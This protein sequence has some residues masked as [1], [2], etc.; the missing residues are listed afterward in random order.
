MILKTDGIK[1]DILEDQVQFF[2]QHGLENPERLIKESEV[3][4]TGHRRAVYRHGDG[5]FY[6]K[7]M[8]PRK[9]SKEWRNW[10]GLY[11]KGVRTAVP[12]AMGISPDHGY[13]ISLAHH[14]WSGLYE[15]FDAGGYRQ[16]LGVLQAL[17]RCIRTMHR[18]GFYHGDLH[19]GNFLARW[20][21]GK[22]DIVMVDF[23]RGRFCSLSR[24]QRLANLAGLAVS[25]YFFLTVRER[26]AFLTG[27]LGGSRAACN[28]L[29]REGKQLEALIL[30]RASRVADRKV[31][32]FR[33]VN[34]Y[35][36]RLTVGAPGYKGVCFRQNQDAV[37]G[38][39]LSSPLEFLYGNDLHVLKDSRSVRVVRC[40]DICIKY[41]KRRGPKDV[42]KGRL[43]LS[44]GKKSFRWALAL[45]YRSI[46]TPD[47]L[48]YVDGQRGD[49]F[50]VSR[51]LESGQKL[52]VHLH[53]ASPQQREAC[54]KALGP[55]LKT[56]FYRGIYHLDLKSSNILVTTPGR[57]PGFYLIDTDGVAIFWKGSRTLLRKSLLRIT[58]ALSQYFDGEALI[59]FVL[60]CLS[61]LPDRL[62]LTSSPEEL[63]TRAFEIEA[64]RQRKSAQVND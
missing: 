24:R 62:T 15:I 17:G 22:P 64:G 9:A 41:Y 1:W 7:R 47:P 31:R 58:R 51:F 44:K 23:Q 55:F 28:F 46:P 13:L 36:D 59:D 14:G 43:G 56:L 4:K 29:R 49:S 19:G 57:G 30:E 50:Y 34:K 42:L 18:A 61:G 33:N 35:F 48:C 11:E 60:S 27:Y 8:R 54:L 16:R 52:A 26:L 39:F 21:R 53:E 2:R 25:H 6:V 38:A 5:L 3:V 10:K 37:P 12:V 20:N 45:M 40:H 63:V 32:R